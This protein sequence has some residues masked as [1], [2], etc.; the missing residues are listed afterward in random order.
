[1]RN[2][3]PEAISALRKSATLNPNDPGTHNNLGLAYLSMGQKE[4][5]RKEL[6]KTLDLD[7]SYSDAYIN[8][9]SMAMADKKYAE[10]KRYFRKS[11]ENLE[12]KPRHR[13][14]TAL[15]QI[16]L[17]ENNTDEARRLL[18]QSLQVNPDYCMSHLLLGNIYAQD[19]SPRAAAG[20]FKKSIQKTCV[21]NV[22]GHY[23]LALAYLKIKEYAKAKSE[24]MLLVDQFPETI[25]GQKAGDQLRNIP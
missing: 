10:A 7:S 17:H 20:E 11:L 3:G 24:L 16:A 9:G 22:Q 1:M 18:Y 25:E 5:A 12:F 23:Q 15:A 19:N 21:S 2:D 13:A 8:L 14:L 4:M 6:E